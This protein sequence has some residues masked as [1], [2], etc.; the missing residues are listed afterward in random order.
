MTIS[1]SDV[2][3]RTLM[4]KANS[5]MWSVAHA[6]DGFR[7][8]LFSKFTKGVKEEATMNSQMTVQQQGRNRRVARVSD[9]CRCSLRR[10]CSR[11]SNCFAK[12]SEICS[13]LTLGGGNAGPARL[14]EVQTKAIIICIA[15]TVGAS[16]VSKAPSR[17][18]IQIAIQ[19][20]LRRTTVSTFSDVSRNTV[21]SERGS[22]YLHYRVHYST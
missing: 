14:G 15:A 18:P 19:K 3:S 2:S 6:R 13:R 12:T 20:Q 9:V 16:L 7:R 8:I 1:P 11:Q 17:E 21:K 10:G 4:A 5:V 22:S